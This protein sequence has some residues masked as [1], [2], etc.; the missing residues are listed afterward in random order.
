MTEPKEIK[1][2]IRQLK[3]LKLACQPG[4]KER[5]DLHRKIKDLKRQLVEINTFEPGKDILIKKI[6]ELEPN[7]PKDLVNLNKFTEA[8]LQK[9]IECVKRKTGLDR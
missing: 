6:L 8:E 3:K 5:I 1:K 2:E 7:F 4:S 9:H